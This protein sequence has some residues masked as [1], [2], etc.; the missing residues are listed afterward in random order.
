VAE[1]EDLPGVANGLYYAGSGNGGIMPIEANYMPGTGRLK[2][3][4][5]FY[6]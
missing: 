3:T 2:L 4:G 5:E 1:A 6:V